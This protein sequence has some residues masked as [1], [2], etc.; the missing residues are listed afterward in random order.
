M[1]KKGLFTVILLSRSNIQWHLF[2][3]QHVLQNFA[4]WLFQKRSC[5]HLTIH[6]LPGM[7]GAVCFFDLWSPGAQL[8]RLLQQSLPYLAKLQHPDA[9]LDEDVQES[10]RFLPSF[11]FSGHVFFF[12]EEDTQSPGTFTLRKINTS[13]KVKFYLPTP[14]KCSGDV[15]VCRGATKQKRTD[16]LAKTALPKSSKLLGKFVTL[17][18]LSWKKRSRRRMDGFD[19]QKVGNSPQD[20]PRFWRRKSPLLKDV[21]HANWGDDDRLF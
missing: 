15:L 18:V 3:F 17:K 6:P 2:F 9:S 5:Y 20:P 19:P 4:K 7:S 1:T 8:V 13:T 10:L 14:S 12:R 11:F 21:I 16:P